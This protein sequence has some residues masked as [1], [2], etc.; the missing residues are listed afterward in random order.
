MIKMAICSPTLQQVYRAMLSL[1]R[2]EF[3]GTHR[4][5][6]YLRKTLKLKSQL[7]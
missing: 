3:D 7:R 4:L 5:I 1:K 2:I 6:L